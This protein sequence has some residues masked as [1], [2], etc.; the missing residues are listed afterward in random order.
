MFIVVGGFN[1][2]NQSEICQPFIRQQKKDVFNTKIIYGD[3]RCSIG[4]VH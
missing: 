4:K 1:I 2:G 3:I